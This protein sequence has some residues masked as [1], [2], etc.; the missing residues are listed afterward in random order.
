MQ[1]MTMIVTRGKYFNVTCSCGREVRFLASQAAA[2]LEARE[3]VAWTA[4][5]RPDLSKYQ[6]GVWRV[7]RSGK[8]QSR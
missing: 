4:S 8:Y 5:G 7:D 1:H 3:H 6:Y 2:D